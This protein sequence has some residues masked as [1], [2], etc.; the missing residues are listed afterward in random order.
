LGEAIVGETGFTCFI[1][2]NILNIFFLRT[3]EPRK[4][5]FACKLSDSIEARLFKSWPRGS[6]EAKGNEMHIHWENIYIW[7]NVTQVSHVAHALLVQLYDGGQFL[8]VK[9]RTQIHYTMYLRRDHQSSASKIAK[10]L[11]YSGRYEQD[12]NRC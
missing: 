2:E 9:E 12:S 11:T 8:L 3:T 1:W 6:G 7:A 5:N 4:L 10:F